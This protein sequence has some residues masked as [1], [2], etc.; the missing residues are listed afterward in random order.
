[1]HTHL[2]FFIG[3]DRRRSNPHCQEIRRISKGEGEAQREH[4][5]I[6]IS[7]MNFI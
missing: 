1:M 3:G 4:V 6:K 7:D 2:S 5:T